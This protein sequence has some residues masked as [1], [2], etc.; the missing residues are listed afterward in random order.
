MKLPAF[1]VSVL[2]VAAGEPTP[3]RSEHLSALREEKVVRLLEGLQERCRTMLVQQTAVYKETVRLHKL[4]QAAPNQEPRPG[5]RR[6]ALR[7]ARA[8]GAI[9]RQATQAADL[10]EADGAAVAFPEVSGKY[11]TTCSRCNA[12]C[13]KGRQ[14]PSRRL[15]KWTSST[16]W[17]K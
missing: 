9:A 2:V 7:L 13:A 16:L 8:E 5:H 6:T 15:C 4:V 17:T 12:F 1:L 10:L 3:R 14:D 11:A